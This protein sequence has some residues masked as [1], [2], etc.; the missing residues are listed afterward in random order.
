MMMSQ[1][2]ALSVLR[3]K[4]VVMGYQVY[5][6]PLR[7]VL[8][9]TSSASLFSYPSTVWSL[10]GMLEGSAQ[11]RNTAGS[12]NS[13]AAPRPAPL[14][15]AF[16]GSQATTPAARKAVRNRHEPLRGI[17][18]SPMQDVSASLAACGLPSFL[19]GRPRGRSPTAR[20]RR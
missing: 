6:T 12:T 14:A 19:A 2:F 9:A 17:I 18:Q 3:T 13:P 5:A 4:P 15:P 11:T 16:D 7:P 8:L 1:R 20:A 10:E